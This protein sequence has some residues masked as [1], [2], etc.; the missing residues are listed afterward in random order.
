MGQGKNWTAAEVEY[1]EDNWGSV[2][3]P[4]LA[5][6]LERS[7]SAVKTKAFKLELGPYLESGDYIT[8]NQLCIALGRKGVH[9][10]TLRSWVKERG[11]P[12]RYRRVNQC[13]F[14]VVY[15]NEFWR[16][17]KKHRTFIDFSKV[18]ENALGM[19]PEWVKEQRRHDWDK[20]KKYRTCKWTGLEDQELRRLLREG[21]HTL[22]EISKRLRRTCGAVQQRI[23]TLRITERPV[24]ADNQ[25]DW[26][27]DELRRLDEYI[28]RGMS[29]ELIAEQL[30]RSAK[31]LRG[32]AYV[33]YGTEVL[34]KII[35][36]NI[37]PVKHEQQ[38]Q[39]RNQRRR[40]QKERSEL[41]T[42]VITLL[43]IK[44]NA[45]AFGEYWQKEIC[46]NWHDVRGCQAK[47]HNCDSCVSFIRIRPQY[48]VRCGATIINRDRG[49][50][51]A[52]CAEQRKKQAQRKYAITHKPQREKNAG[53]P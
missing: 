33:L 39:E 35:Q 15:L 37:D 3:L 13:R 16:W 50:I 40:E 17:A 38:K 45:M 53:R 14:R 36:G 49:K 31:A 29:Y 32:K 6:Q 12:V 10:Y 1:L 2:S 8:L 23:I 25:I 9:T 19:E 20:R 51:C 30:G 28:K 42:K 27:D 48:C 5:K 4:S 47:E 18:E 41:M 26:T 21:T 34:D 7:V 24:R 52:R 22:D 11:L 43:L 46:M 44:R